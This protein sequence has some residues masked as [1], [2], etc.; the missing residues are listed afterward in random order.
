MEE[1]PKAARK[2]FQ[3]NSCQLLIETDQSA[4]LS[5]PSLTQMTSVT[6]MSVDFS[7]AD[8][9]ESVHQSECGDDGATTNF[10]PFVSSENS[11][12]KTKKSEQIVKC[13][14]EN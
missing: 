7:S 6:L 8:E 13:C 12:A 1:T 14:Y 2:L 4:E 3:S 5:E 9:Y 11:Q 10:N